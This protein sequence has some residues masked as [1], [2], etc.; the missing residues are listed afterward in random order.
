M[1]VVVV[2]KQKGGV[3]ASTSVRELGIAAAAAGKRVI[4]IDTN[5]QDTSRSYGAAFPICHPSSILASMQGGQEAA[6]M[7][8]L[9]RHGG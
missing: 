1:R 6:P 3:G 8:A 2:A 7:P 5:A 9:S 4:L